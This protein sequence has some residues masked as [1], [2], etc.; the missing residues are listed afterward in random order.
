MYWSATG[1][2]L[3]GQAVLCSGEQGNPTGCFG[4]RKAIICC[5]EVASCLGKKLSPLAG[6]AQPPKVQKGMKAVEQFAESRSL[7]SVAELPSPR[8]RVP[9]SSPEGSSHPG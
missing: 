9:G 7:W 4:L 3:H 8:C 2:S 5:A 6:S 1:Q